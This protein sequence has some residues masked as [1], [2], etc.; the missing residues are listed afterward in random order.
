MWGAARE[1]DRVPQELAEYGALIFVIGS[2]VIVVKIIV[3]GV[4]FGLAWYADQA[5]KD[6]D[7]EAQRDQ[8]LAR[9]ANRLDDHERTAEKR[10]EAASSTADILAELL[11]ELRED[12][13]ARAQ[14]I[15]DAVGAVAGVIT[16]SNDVQT[17]TLRVIIEDAIGRYSEEVE[18]RV[19]RIERMPER[20][21][22]MLRAAAEE[23][24]EEFSR[25][26][27]QLLGKLKPLVSGTNTEE[28]GNGA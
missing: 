7:A 6:R 2:L 23:T 10:L 27:D 8:L 24:R 15:E 28:S 25:S 26:M 13:A 9:L 20:F 16:N 21:K 4:K 18:K 11:K 12:K 19:E 5:Q 3:E 14:I 22:E 1:E 17:E